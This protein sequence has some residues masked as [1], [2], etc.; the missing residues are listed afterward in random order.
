MALAAGAGFAAVT[1]TTFGT[2]FTATGALTGAGFE[3]A[4]AATGLAAGF[5]AVNFGFSTFFG[6]AGFAGFAAA[7]LVGMFV[8][9]Q[10]RIQK[11][12][13]L[14]DAGLYRPTFACTAP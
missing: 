5:F 2:G 9:L 4:L 14:Q 10:A 13:G 12:A 11:G 1:G 7:R 6:L 3:E 8:S